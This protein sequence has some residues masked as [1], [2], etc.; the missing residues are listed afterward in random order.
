[1]NKQR[2]VFGVW[3]TTL[4]VV[5]LGAVPTRLV[6][7]VNSYDASFDAIARRH[8]YYRAFTVATANQVKVDSGS[9]D[10]VA[11]HH[12]YYQAFMAATAADSDAV[13]LT[14]TDNAPYDV[15][16][17]RHGYY[18]ALIAATTAGVDAVAGADMG[19]QP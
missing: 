19:V 15:V 11:R 4:A 17:Q 10:T 8:G 7:Q 6:A 9:Y 18:R 1:M 3:V 5:A 2:L 12:G 16:A 14:P 13:A